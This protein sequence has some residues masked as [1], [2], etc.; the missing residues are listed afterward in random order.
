MVSESSSAG[1]SSLFVS[2]VFVSFSR[3]CRV[4]VCLQLLLVPTPSCWL[5]TCRR[6]ADQTADCWI[7]RLTCKA[8]NILG[9]SLVMLFSP[10]FPWNNLFLFR[11]L[12]FLS[13]VSNYDRVCV[14]VQYLCHLAWISM[15]HCII[16]VFSNYPANKL[17]QLPSVLFLSVHDKIS[18]VSFFFFF[19]K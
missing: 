9:L 10:S 12:C 15:H 5:F 18:V 16:S 1:L 13:S 17:V 11:P 19:L 6:S 8:G 2:L 4:C 14:C 3:P 7:I